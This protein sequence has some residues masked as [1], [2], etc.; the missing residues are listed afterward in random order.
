MRK[1]ATFYLLTAEAAEQDSALSVELQLTCH[2]AALAWRQNKRVLIACADEQQ[3][4]LLDELLWQQ[5]VE[6]FVPHN[7]AGEGPKAG[8]PVELSWPNKRSLAARQYLINLQ[9]TVADFAPLFNEVIDFVPAE[10]SR[11]TL[12]R[13]RYKAYRQVG[14]H[15]TTA[16]MP[17]I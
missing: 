15:L 7:L 1:Q 17:T 11:K 2:F 4:L 8:A 5:P 9:P 16:A 10:E 3:A 12:A 6:H 14:F 13:D